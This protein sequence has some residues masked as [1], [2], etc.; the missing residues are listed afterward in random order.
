MIN[1]IAAAAV[2]KPG[3]EEEKLASNSIGGLLDSEKQQ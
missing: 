3:A 2:E 1:Q